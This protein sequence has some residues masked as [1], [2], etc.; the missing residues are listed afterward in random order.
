MLSLSLLVGLAASAAVAAPASSSSGSASS[1]SSASSHSPS[2]TPDGY[3]SDKWVRAFKKAQDAVAKMT[4]DEKV[5]FTTLRYDHGDC[6]GLTY[7]VE[8][9]GIPSICF[10]GGGTGIKTRY[11]SQFPTEVTTGATWDRD[12]IT[13]RAAAMGKENAEL[14]IHV[15][16]PF[17]AGPIGR[18]P[19][20]GRDWENFSPD[21]YLTGEAIK[22][23]VEAYQKSGSVGCVKHF[24]GNEQEWLRQGIAQGGYFGRQIY[25]TLGDEIDAATTRELYTWPFAEAVRSGAGAIMCSYDKINGTMVCENDAVLNGLLKEELGFGGYV[26]TDWGATYHALDAAVNG[27][28]FVEGEGEEMNTWGD[29]LGDLVRNGSLPKSIYD[30]KLVRI[31]TPYFALDQ[32]KLPEIDFDRYVASAAHAKVVRDTAEGSLTL[33]KNARSS[34]DARGLPLQNPKDLI[35]VGSAASAARYGQPDNLAAMFYITNETFIDGFISEGFG[36]GGSTSPYAIDPLAGIRAR[37]MKQERPT[38][39]DGYFSDNATEGGSDSHLPSFGYIN[40]LDYKLSYADTAVVF[41]AVHQQDGY[42][43]KNLSLPHDGDDLIKYVAERHNDTV[44][45]VTAPGPVDM[46]A[47]IDHANVSSVV[48][49]YFPTVEGGNAIASVL[50]GDVNPSGK[51]PFTIA[52]NV[53]DYPDAYYNGSLVENPVTNFT[54]GVFIDYKHF[55]AKNITPL[56]EFGYGMSYTNFS[57]SSLKVQRTKKHSPAPVRETNEKLYVND[58]LTS[59][60]YDI[61]YTVKA[62]IKNTGAVAGAEVAQLYITFPGSVPRTLPIRSLRGFEKPFLKAGESKTVSFELRNKDLAYYSV[63]KAGWVIPAGE[64]TVSVGSSS[65]ELPLT[66][67]FEF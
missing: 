10:H 23:S 65:R 17:V 19:Y 26:L 62:T 29:N 1:T 15:G 39:V 48:F 31:F 9:I 54:E 64:F 20:G 33:L 13:A 36:S 40:Y 58:E 52:Q 60:L 45:V 12:V 35:L 44:V 22:L 4:L 66:A 34:D 41:V 67:S 43:R 57:Y 42:D 53:S 55:D 37:A 49:A 16:L 51:L 28:D 38:Y 25:G 3:T 50:F 5:N 21:P 56:Y 63:W 11:S 46:S 32:A 8:S 30:D 14:G 6:A 24:F 2:L 27:T 47:W 59:G 7:P 18:S 61:A